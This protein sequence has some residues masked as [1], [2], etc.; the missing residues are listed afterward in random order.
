MLF[1]EF[2]HRKALLLVNA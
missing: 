2:V 1:G